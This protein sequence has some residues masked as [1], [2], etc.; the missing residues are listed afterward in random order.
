MY[1]P[2]HA[3]TVVQEVEVRV[4]DA[5]TDST[6]VQEGIDELTHELTVLVCCVDEG[7]EIGL[8]VG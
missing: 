2:L 3:K 7:C 6:C 8:C 1:L 5:E 4:E